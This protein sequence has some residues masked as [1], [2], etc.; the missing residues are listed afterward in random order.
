[1]RDVSGMLGIGL[2]AYRSIEVGAR[3]HVRLCEVLLIAQALRE[4]P[5]SLARRAIEAGL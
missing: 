2:Y 3:Q 5:N 1:M 4:P